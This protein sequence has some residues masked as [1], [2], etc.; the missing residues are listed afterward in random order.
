M[1]KKIIRN[2]CIG[3]SLFFLIGACLYK[4]LGGSYGTTEETQEV[5]GFSTRDYE[6]EA[7]EIMEAHRK[8]RADQDYAELIDRIDK[9]YVEYNR[10]Y[11]YEK[12][13]IA[14]KYR[15]IVSIRYKS[16]EHLTKLKN[17]AIRA[18]ELDKKIGEFDTKVDME[19]FMEEGNQIIKECANLP[20]YMVNEFENY[21]KYVSI[22]NKIDNYEVEYVIKL[23]DKI[24][25]VKYNKKTK[26]KILKAGNAYYALNYNKQKEVTN[27]SKFIKK[28][29]KYWKLEKK[30]I[31]YNEVLFDHPWEE[32]QEVY[33]RNKRVKDSSDSSKKDDD[34]NNYNSG[35][36]HSSLNEKNVDPDDYDSGEDYADDAW[37][38]DFDDWDDAYE[39]WEDEA[40]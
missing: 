6:R 32:P 1:D 20:E 3:F 14:S 28:R 22:K 11:D 30:A 9:L 10:M 33:K 34:N 27:Y 4:T 2:V 7:D 35:K 5:Y 19:Q 29:K 23:I 36:S 31:G 8:C 13:K 25:K 37:G 12:E 17:D 16:Y 15:L 24:G 21:Y 38:D 40:Y 18:A 39:Y 26:E